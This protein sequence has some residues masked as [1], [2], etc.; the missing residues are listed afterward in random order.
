M[1]LSDER[2]ELMLT[3]VINNYRRADYIKTINDVQ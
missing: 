3:I 1:T 2:T